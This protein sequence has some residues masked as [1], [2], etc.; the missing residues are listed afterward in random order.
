LRAAA[1]LKVALYGTQIHAVVPN[2]E[3]YKQPIT[4]MLEDEGVQV[5]GVEWIAPSL[6]DVFISAVKP[7]RDQGCS[8][9][10]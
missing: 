2:A 4:A 6:E 1:F 10:K 7:S 5:Q 8:V 9:L 3:A